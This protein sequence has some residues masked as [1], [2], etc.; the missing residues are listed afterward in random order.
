M[1]INFSCLTNQINPILSFSYQLH[2]HLNFFNIP[3]FYLKHKK[4]SSFFEIFTKDQKNKNAFNSALKLFTESSKDISDILAQQSLDV[5]LFY[6]LLGLF[7]NILISLTIVLPSDLFKVKDLKIEAKKFI[8]VIAV[9]LALKLLIFNEV[10]NQTNDISS[11]IVVITVAILLRLVI[12]IF[13]LKLDRYKLH[14]FDNDILYLLLIGH[15]FFTVSVAS[16]SFIEEEHQI[17]YYLCS[18][19]FILL[20]FYEFRGRRSIESFVNVVAQCLPVLLLHVFIRRMNQ[21]GDKWI[22]TPDIGDWLHAS[23]NGEW[24]NV[25]VVV[26]IFLSLSWLAVRHVHGMVVLP[27]VILAHVALYLHHTRSVVTSVDVPTTAVF[28]AC[29]VL[30]VVIAMVQK[31]RQ[32]SQSNGLFLAFV[33]VSMLLHQPQNIG[34]CFCIGVTSMLINHA[35]H[36]MIKNTHERIVAKVI[37]HWWIGKMFY[38]YQVRF[39][40]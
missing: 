29:V 9:M 15:A 40:F 31:W 4:A 36:R 35:A 27:V 14:L 7:M 34:M 6:V 39:H 11:F 19:M 25:V 12:D 37:M 5:N 23:G 26:S 32:K 16:S 8:P 20:T 30:I 17:W 33:L 24:L 13:I 21:T 38:F 22:N 3:E 1:A 10:F 28:W 18:A 2:H